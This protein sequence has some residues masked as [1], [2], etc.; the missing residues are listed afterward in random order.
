VFLKNVLFSNGYPIG[1]LDNCVKTF[2]DKRFCNPDA[3]STVDKCPFVL[4]L[5]FLGKS[6]FNLRRKIFSAFSNTFPQISLKIIFTSKTKIPNLFNFKDRVPFALRSGVVYRFSCGN[7][8]VAYVGKTTRH[9]HTR[10]CE[11]L[12]ISAKTGNSV[13]VCGQ[14]AVHDHVRMC[15]YN[16]SIDDFEILAS[17]DNEFKLLVVESIFIK[18]LKPVLNNQLTSVPLQLL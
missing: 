8:N 17:C 5:P 9:L 10:V 18:R 3:V 6:S 1:F 12:G 13:K 15:Q 16:A 2:L 4:V 7:C 11:H 14:S